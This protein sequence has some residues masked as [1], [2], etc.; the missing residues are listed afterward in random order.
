M[1]TI[2]NLEIQNARSKGILFEGEEQI[3]SS[4]KITILDI[5]PSM[6]NVGKE[7]AK[8]KGYLDEN[9]SVHIRM[10]FMTADAHH[11]PY[12]DNSFDAYTIAFGIRNCTDVPKVVAEAHR[13]LKKGGRFLCLEFSHVNTI[14]IKEFY[15]FYSF[16]VIPPMGALVA[17]DWNSYQYL[18]ESIRQFPSVEAFADIIHSAGFSSVSYKTFN[19]GIVAVH[20]GFK[21]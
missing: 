13:V 4:S 20:S 19:F 17:N 3:K 12:P 1:E 18:V 7:R 14:G 15:D 8:A 6:L 10:D 16:N 11:L 21:L 9:A 2:K 5:N